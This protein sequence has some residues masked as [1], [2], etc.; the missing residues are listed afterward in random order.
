MEI[1]DMVK[2]SISISNPALEIKILKT[3]TPET[4]KPQNLF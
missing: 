4:K 1:T 2:I 3:N